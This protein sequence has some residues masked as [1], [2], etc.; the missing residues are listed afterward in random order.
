MEHEIR[1]C[2]R[3]PS[4]LCMASIAPGLTPGFVR[5]VAYAHS[6]SVNGH[7]LSA[8]SPLYLID[9]RVLRQC[10]QLGRS[11]EHRSFAFLHFS[12]ANASFPEAEFSR[13][14]PVPSSVSPF[15][16]DMTEQPHRGVQF[17]K[18][19]GIC[20]RPKVR[21]DCPEVGWRKKEE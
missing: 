13:S 16:A 15:D 14:R 19:R 3:I 10:E 21:V 5:F 11:F 9:S 4:R 6:D 17:A 12:H 1:H 20:I 2:T 8:L 7:Q 18:D